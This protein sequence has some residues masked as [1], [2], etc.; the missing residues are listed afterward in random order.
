M[1]LDATQQTA[2]SDKER[3]RRRKEKLCFRCRKPG[4][5]SNTCKQQTWKGKQGGK[6]QLQ[7]TKELSA[8][9]GRDGYDT[10]GSGVIIGTIRPKKVNKQLRRLYKDCTTLSDEEIK[11][12]L[13]KE[14]STDYESTNNDWPTRDSNVL[15]ATNQKSPNSDA[16]SL[17]DWE[18]ITPGGLI[19]QWTTLTNEIRQ[20][21]GPDLEN[22]NH[23]EPDQ[24]DFPAINWTTIDQPIDPLDEEYRTQWEGL[25]PNEE[26]PHEI[27]ET[28]RDDS[29][30]NNDEADQYAAWLRQPDRKQLAELEAYQLNQRILEKDRTQGETGALRRVRSKD[31]D[32]DA[33]QSKG[34]LKKKVT[35]SQRVTAVLAATKPSRRIAMMEL[36]G[37]APESNNDYAEIMTPDDDSEEESETGKTNPRKIIPR[38]DVPRNTFVPEPHLFSATTNQEHENPGNL[39]PRNSEVRNNQLG[40]KSNTEAVLPQEYAKFKTLFEQ[41]KQYVLPKYAGHGVLFVP[42]KDGS[43]RLCVDYRPLNVITIKDRYPLPLIHEIQDR[44]RGAKWFMKLDITD[45]YNHLRIA[46]GEEW[47]TAFRTKFGHYEYLVMPFGLTNAPASFERFIEEVLRKYLHLFV[48]VYLDDILIFSE[49]EEQHVEHVSLVL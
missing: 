4:H 35:T 42:K 43:L 46:E 37:W 8:T 25:N 41:P 7:A 6:K 12:E 5:M 24:E 36:P 13:K 23:D 9:I 15:A 27:P 28:P 11:V 14:D 10:T 17:I 1:E 32:N 30:Q 49:N 2:L 29:P 18:N 20:V 39:D 47:K 48:I 19:H 22:T 3:E 44:I 21:I 34:G 38:N 31:S 45:A 16:D 40:N 26:Q 33:K